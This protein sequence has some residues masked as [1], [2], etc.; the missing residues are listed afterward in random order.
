MHD[1]TQTVRPEQTFRKTND[2]PTNWKTS[3][4]IFYVTIIQSAKTF[5]KLSH[6]PDFGMSP[7]NVT[8]V[9]LFICGVVLQQH[10]NHIQNWVAH[11]YFEDITVGVAKKGL[12]SLWDEMTTSTGNTVMTKITPPIC[13]YMIFT[14]ILFCFAIILVCP[15]CVTHN[16]HVI[17]RTKKYA[18]SKI[19][20]HWLSAEHEYS[21]A[22][23]RL[24]TPTVSDD[25]DLSIVMR[26]DARPQ[27]LQCDGASALF[28]HFPCWNGTGL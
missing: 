23:G 14:W 6:C 9:W 4:F 12:T 1:N 3:L 13:L 11:S 28:S 22:S 5:A 20:I 10:S 8:L 7:E 17:R 18:N 16:H 19:P 15:L 27:S 24:N 21:Q 2:H 26:C 25:R